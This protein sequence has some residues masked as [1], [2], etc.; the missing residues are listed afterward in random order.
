MASVETLPS[1]ALGLEREVDD[2]DAVLL[3]NADQQDDADDGD[4]AEILAED[5]EREQRANAGRGQRG[6]NC[7]GVDEA[8]I[9]D[10]E[11]DVD[12][13]QR[14]ENQQRFV[15]ERVL[16]RRRGALEIGLQAGGKVK[17]LGNLVDVLIAVPSDALGAR[18]N[19]TVTEG[20]CP[21]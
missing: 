16:E 12:G 13:D 10:A 4:D 15:G 6:K 17:V 7:D 5:D 3:H 19:E 9:E 2:H 11:H 14:G 20:N 21:W 8:L 18:L 1:L